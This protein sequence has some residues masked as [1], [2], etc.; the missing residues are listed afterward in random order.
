MPIHPV[1]LRVTLLQSRYLQ[2][3]ESSQDHETNARPKK[4]LERFFSNRRDE[5]FE[6]T[7]HLTDWFCKMA[8]R[9]SCRFFLD[10]FVYRELFKKDSRQ[11]F[12][13]NFVTILTDFQNSFTDMVNN[14]QQHGIS[15]PYLESMITPVSAVSTRRRHLRSAGLGDVV[16]RTRTVGFGPRSFSVAGPSLWNTLPIDTKVASLTVSFRNQLKT[17]MFLRSYFALAQPS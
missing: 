6:H 5:S 11:V 12:V 15:A 14:L 3:L 1:T 16:P 7:W 10:F 4:F 8:S 13:I 17:E 9:P 2:I